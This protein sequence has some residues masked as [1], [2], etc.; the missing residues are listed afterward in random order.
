M[1]RMK[2]ILLIIVIVF[3]VIQVVRPN[4]TNPPVDPQH[5]IQN[6]PPDVQA[7]L[8]RSCYDCHSS[9]TR[10]PWYSQVVP[11]SWL[12]KHDVDEGRQELSFSEF[13][14]YSPK[15]S[16]RTM[17]AI[18]DEVKSGDMPLWQYRPLHPDA[19]LSDADRQALCAWAAAHR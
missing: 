8:R 12:L 3:V 5:R 4:L 19:K 2:W 14:T 17:K 9:E 16:A 11:V 1:S 13:A 18:C 7:I 10:W 15:K 6:V